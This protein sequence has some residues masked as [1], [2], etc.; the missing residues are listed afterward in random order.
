MSRESE[1][2]QT[3]RTVAAAKDVLVE[4]A[5]EVEVCVLDLGETLHLDA[6]AGGNPS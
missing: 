2:E 5:P 1:S 3:Q 4:L 6:I